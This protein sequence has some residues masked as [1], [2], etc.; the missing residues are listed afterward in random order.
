[1]SQLRATM[2]RD[3]SKFN[4]IKRAMINNVDSILNLHFNNLSNK[5]YKN[6]NVNN[7]K[8]NVQ[9]TCQ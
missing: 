4:S 5:N 6:K 9:I 3:T 1:M 7:M 8:M 2:R